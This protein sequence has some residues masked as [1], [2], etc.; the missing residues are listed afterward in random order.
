MPEALDPFPQLRALHKRGIE[1]WSYG[2][3]NREAIE[4]SVDGLLVRVCGLDHL[5]AM[6][7]R[8]AD[9]GTSKT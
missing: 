4:S 8:R 7:A 1:P 5:R 3:L 9:R 6:K 2:E